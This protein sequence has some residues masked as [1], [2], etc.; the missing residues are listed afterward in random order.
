MAARARTADL[1]ID[2]GTSTTRLVTQ[3]RGIVAVAPSLVAMTF[4][5]GQREPVAIG[6]AALQMLGR[7]PTGTEVVRPVQTGAVAD[8][9]A[10][11][12]LVRTLLQEAGLLGLR[13]PRILVSVPSGSSDVEHR[14]IRECIRAAGAG[15]V[16]TIPA[17]I[18][19]AVGADL[20]IHAPV[21]SVIV[22]LGAGRSSIAVLSA[23][24]MVTQDSLALGGDAFDAAIVAWTQKERGLII[25]PRTS[26]ALK[27]SAA[28]LLPMGQPL[29]GTVRGRDAT[30]GRPREDEIDSTA[31]IHALESPSQRIRRLVLDTLARTPPELASDIVDRGLLI[32]GGASDIRGIDRILRM[33]TSLPVLQTNEPAECVARG[34]SRVLGDTDLL[35]RV[36][37]ES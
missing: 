34:M 21:A 15:A 20:P 12:R 19:A 9:E 35:E 28:D 14:A 31:L 30:T 37:D 32:C 18:A 2:L 17:P 24:G 26:E 3:E 23:G 8:F 33:D 4:R 16:L 36:A 11:E 10:A 6:E 5:D 29:R 25:G 1:A 27:R 22:D 13:K 7:A